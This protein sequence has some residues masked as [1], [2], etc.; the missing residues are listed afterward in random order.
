M[1]KEELRVIPVKNYIVLG[2]ILL[3]SFFIIKAIFLN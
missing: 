3:V 2:I 1:K